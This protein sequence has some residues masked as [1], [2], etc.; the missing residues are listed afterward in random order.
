MPQRTLAG[1]TRYVRS[2]L[3]LKLGLGLALGMTIMAGA[4]CI[5]MFSNAN[6]L[7]EGE[8]QAKLD[9]KS[10]AIAKD[11][12]NL[13]DKAAGE[14]VLARENPAFEGY[15]SASSAE[16]RAA[17]LEAVHAQMR[18]LQKRFSID[19]ICLIDV[20]GQEI[21]RI[22]GTEIAGNDDLSPDEAEAP[23]FHPSLALSDGEVY[24]TEA[25]YLSPD[26]DQLVVAFATPVQLDDGYIAGLLHFEIPLAWFANRAN[27]D[28]LSG[29]YSFLLSSDGQVLTEPEPLDG[30]EN[31]SEGTAVLRAD[32]DSLIRSA[33]SGGSGYA[34]FKW[35]GESYEAGYRPALGGE[36]VVV[37]ALPHDVIF[38][39]AGN[40]R[41][42]ALLVAVPLLAI[43]V[44]L[45]T[46]YAGRLLRP[47]RKLTGAAHA[48]AEG[49]LDT[50]ISVN[51]SDEL[52][53]VAAAFREMTTSLRDMAAGADAIS[54]G[55][56]SRTTHVRSAGDMLGTSL[57]RMT[58][59]LRD[60]VGQVQ[61]ATG[62]IAAAALQL[63]ATSLNTGEA[64]DQVRDAV[65]GIAS[66]ATATTEAAHLAT[67]A[68][69]G[70]TAGFRQIEEGATTQSTQVQVASE[71]AARFAASSAE[72]ASN[73]TAAVGATRQTHDAA[74]NGE[75]AVQDTIAAMAEIWD[76][77]NATAETVNQ[78]GELGE[79]IGAV[80][81]TIH[82]IAEETNLLALNAAIEAAR[83]GE[84]GRGF[85]V[86][87]GEVRRLSERVR[88]E[89]QAVAGLIAGVQNVTREAVSAI[90]QGTAKV[91]EGRLRSEQAGE[92]LSEIL[93]TADLVGSQAT[94][95][96]G[97][98]EQSSSGANEISDALA[99]ISDVAE[100]NRTA[101]HDMARQ[102]DQVGHAVSDIVD[103][104]EG[105]QGAASDVAA[106]GV[107][108]S[109]QVESLNSEASE[110]SKAADRLGHMVAGFVLDRTAPKLVKMPSRGDKTA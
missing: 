40:L 83:A 103:I 11:I 45:M 93:R 38:A 47:L 100:Q 5:L 37:T 39:P 95:I 53:Q 27:E 44:T 41:K 62:T 68:V 69:S 90:S 18:F 13:A 81:E 109:T 52:G 108:M 23:F 26:T 28:P 92:A 99:Q 63:T 12:D 61:S 7:F 91:D 46:L 75:R 74:R 106:L 66:G 73:A 9:R 6:S 51:G 60:V 17:A 48:I 3:R 42:D 110:L 97:A 101:T 105:N 94:W 29:G 58:T 30:H 98:L 49:D 15:F 77:V 72:A 64:V 14:L 88:S 31:S 107:Q 16:E 57:Q 8:A 32:D 55:D 24:M 10:D 50:E 33:L 70:L 2:S 85:A 80:V 65:D 21:A 86:V 54:D 96:A 22:V 20:T 1:A 89:T 4:L 78:L 36:W 34:S 71:T 84:N 25:P 102:A 82:N 35:K 19:E 79:E 76:V 56:L 87:A 43:A 67:T 104:A 59:N